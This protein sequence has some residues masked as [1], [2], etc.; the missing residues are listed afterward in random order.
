MKLRSLYELAIEKGIDKDPRGKSFVKN[1]LQKSKLK[2]NKLSDK[3]KKDFDLERLKNP[4]SDTRILWGSG[5]EEVKRV[6]VGIDIEVGEIMLADRLI[7]KG[8]KI[9]LILSHHPEGRALA[10]LHQVMIMQ[11]DIA[12]TFGVPITIAE[13]L[14]KERISEV[15]RRLLPINHT[16]TIDAARLLGIPFMC[17]H[18]PADNQ[19]TT[20]L[21]NLIDKK[22]P[23]TLG[24][25]LDILKAIT[26][27]KQA[28]INN[29]G[30]KI[31]NGSSD[32]RPGKVFVDMTGGT[33]GSKKMFKNLAQA[34]VGTVIGMHIGEEHLKL[35]KKEHLNVIIAGHISSDNLGVNLLLDSIEKTQ[36]LEIIE[37]SGFTRNKR[38]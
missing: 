11:A 23:D 1:E 6:M 12:N 29:A 15:E 37:C 27:Y 19:V 20:F 33:G 21:Q 9:D 38:K 18:T 22:A 4:Y 32:Q 25:V 24:E 34:G 16:R 17:V 36:R 13:S 10:S 7:E 28:I 8:K 2:Y 31:L 14:M 26:E 30:P 5:K 3:E 35:A